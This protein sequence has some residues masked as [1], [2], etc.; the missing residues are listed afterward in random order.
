MAAINLA[1]FQSPGVYVKEVPSLIKAITGVSTSTA[2]FIGVFTS[3]GPKTASAE[4]TYDAD[5]AKTAFDLKNYPAILDT[6]T[7]RVLVGDDDKTQDATLTNDDAGKTTLG[8][9]VAPA[10]GK[11]VV[12]YDYKI[13]I[14]VLE[15][16]GKGDGSTTVFNTKPSSFG[17]DQ[18]LLQSAKV[19]LNGTIVDSKKS[20]AIA[21]VTDTNN[22]SITFKN[23]PAKGSSITI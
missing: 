7:F 22:V 19:Y 13:A 1:S 12:R 18:G 11:I 16:L 23:A 8:F 20:V 17:L 3:I 5:G 15:D 9:K 2:G 21:Y 14:Q 4:D 6:G 10:A